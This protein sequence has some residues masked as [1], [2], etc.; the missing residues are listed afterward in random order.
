MMPAGS[1]VEAS[2]RHLAALEACLGSVDPTGI[3]TLA[4]AI[5]QA[6]HIYLSGAG[7]TGMVVEA[8][9]MRLAQIGLAV[10]AA[11]EP[12]APA[13]ID[14]DLLLCASGTG[15]SRAPLRHVEVAR[16]A[17]AKVAA[18]VGQPD[19]ELAGLA[20]WT[21]CLPF[22]SVADNPFP[23]GG[24]FEVSLLIYAALLV[25]EIRHQ[26]RISE[27]DLQRRHANLE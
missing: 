9:A 10:H 19:T 1:Y 27:Q 11:G 5:L 7:R 20:D 24:L 16:S 4:A 14:G 3:E 12:T 21:T 13:I 6:S 8:L 17:G 2:R 25:D 23:L 15:G 22:S 18:I 26:R